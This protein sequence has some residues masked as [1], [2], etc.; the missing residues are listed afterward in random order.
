MLGESGL[1]VRELA[2]QLAEA[3]QMKH[4]FNKEKKAAGKKWLYSFMRR[5]P[6]LSLR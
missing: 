5:H 3:N 1:E 6:Q 2:Y 4:S